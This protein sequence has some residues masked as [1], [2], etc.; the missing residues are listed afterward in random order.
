MRASPV[1]FGARVSGNTAVAYAEFMKIYA[2][3]F[4]SKNRCDNKE[5]KFSSEKGN[6]LVHI[7]Q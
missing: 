7:A 6:M 2:F 5:V 4:L 3:I 1:G